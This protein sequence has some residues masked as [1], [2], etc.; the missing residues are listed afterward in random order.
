VIG[1]AG[2]SSQI[3]ADDRDASKIID[4]FVAH[5]EKADGLD[6]A[7]RAAGL[8]AVDQWRQS[9]DTQPDAITEGLKLAFDEY[10]AALAQAELEP[11]KSVEILRPWIESSDQYLAADARFALARNLMNAERF[12][13]AR[14]L[15]EAVSGDMATLTA[16]SGT[17]L[18]FLGV[19]QARLLEN[20]QAI[21]TLSTFLQRYS[22]AP[23]R[24]RVGAWR[25]IQELAAIEEGQL[26]D[27]HQ[28]M[29]FSRRQLDQQDAGDETQTQ[30]DRIVSILAKL[31][32]EQEKKECSNCNSKKNCQSQNEGQ[33][34][35]QGKKDSE[36]QANKSQQ[37]GKSNNPNGVAQRIYSDGP[38][39]PWSQLR[40]RSRDPAYS[41]IKD[42]LPAK[43]RDIVERY[44]EKA[45]GS[46]P[47][48]GGSR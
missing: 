36:A 45:Q 43:Y 38:A 9:A 32:R 14:P 39:S 17:A 25:Q 29:E 23:E 18:Y 30:Q 8:Q 48:D 10:R 40:D 28:R 24:L 22:D 2:A 27:A 7:A 6:D 4:Q 35:Q 47:A 41:A 15:L 20:R 21:D 42:Q 26:A 46:A 37:G 44:T 3:A 33:A 31:I 16:H 11:A 1:W 12:E 5:L 13:E 34:K 19:A